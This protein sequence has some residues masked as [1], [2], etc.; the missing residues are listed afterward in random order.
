MLLIYGSTGYTGRLIVAEA[1]AR[2]FRPTLAGRNAEAV[3]VHAEPLGLSW[4]AAGLDDTNALDAAL[5]GATVVL[6]CAGPSRG[7]GGQCPTLVSDGVPTIST[8][9][10]RS[11]CSRRS[12]RAMRKRVPRESCCSQASASTSFHPTVSPRIWLGAFQTRRI[13][14]SPFEPAAACRSERYWYNCTSTLGTL[15][16]IVE[17]LGGPDA[18]RRNGRIVPVPP[19][20]K[21]RKIDFGDGR[22]RDATTIPW[23]DVAT[24]WHSTGIPNI[25]VYVTMRLALRRG[26][27][28]SRWIGPLLRTAAERQLLSLM[29]RGS[30]VPKRRR[31]RRARAGP[32]TPAHDLDGML[33]RLHLPTVCRLHGDLATRAEAAT[34][35]A[36]VSRTIY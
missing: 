31:R 26:A 14:R 12:P 17:N 6:H 8:S 21:T 15:S 1:L 9:P 33:R 7:R 3:R 27:V 11:Q 34:T 18:V 19:A 25:E 30:M 16:T 10:A 35:L 5:D 23:G 36:A 13:S 4:C 24:A 2:G 32:P 22:L 29:S 28:L 20:W